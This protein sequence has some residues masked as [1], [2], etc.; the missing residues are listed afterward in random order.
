MGPKDNASLFQGLA[1]HDH[2]D[3]MSHCGAYPTIFLTF[4]DIKYSS[5]ADCIKAMKGVLSSLYL[6][7]ESVLEAANP[8][9]VEKKWV[10]AILE[11]EADTTEYQN[12]LALLTKLLHRATGKKTIV[13]ID[14]YDM[15]IHTGF[16]SGYYSDI[17]DFMRNLLSGAFKDNDSLEKGV[18]TGIM[19]IAKESIFSG[20]NNPRACTILDNEFSQYFGFTQA[21]LDQILT[22][23]QLENR[24]NEVRTWYNGY[25]F[26][27]HTIFNPWS[28]MQYVTAAQRPDAQAEPYWVN[29]SDNQLIRNLITEQDALSKADLETLLRGETIHKE[30]ETNVVLS[31]INTDSLWSMLTQSGYLTSRKT[32]V[33][34]G[35]HHCDLAIPNL[36]V[37]TFF[38]RTVQ[39]WVKKHAGSGG[40]KPMLDA[41]LEEDIPQFAFHFSE[42]VRQTLSYYDTA[43]NAPERVYH[44]FLLGMLITLQNR[45]QVRSNRESGLGRYDILLTPHDP[46]DPGFVFE[47][48]Q[49]ETNPEEAAQKALKQIQAKDYGAVLRQAGVTKARAIGVAL[50]GK[51][52]AFE[53]SLL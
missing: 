47:F 6:E 38:S 33:S 2:Q 31:N 11:G 22:D 12:A 24:A 7:F 43:G 20:F 1:I 35:I 46:H 40:L 8:R 18:L 30:L 48:K 3:I 53:T 39:A 45:Y 51:Q 21:E 13:L 16:K 50:C 19:R 44:V 26:G 32:I 29:T 14:E 10:H 25:Q 41:L 15:P 34:Q 27:P 28:I 36:E 5:F 42:A 23:F 9:G 52:V 49:T 37:R 4:K 17:I